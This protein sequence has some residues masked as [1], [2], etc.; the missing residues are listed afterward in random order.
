MRDV[1]VLYYTIARGSYDRWRELL[2][3]LFGDNFNINEHVFKQC[4]E[5]FKRKV[6]KDNKVLQERLTKY[7]DRETTEK[8]V[9]AKLIQDND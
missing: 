7:C 5:E 2:Q 6:S 8:Q 4:E 3:K 1:G 9:K